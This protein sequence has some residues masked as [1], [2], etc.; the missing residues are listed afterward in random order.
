MVLIFIFL[1]VPVILLIFRNTEF[2]S[3][4]LGRSITNE[5]FLSVNLDADSNFRNLRIITFRN[6]L[7]N[8]EHS[9]LDNDIS[10]IDKIDKVNKVRKN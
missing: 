1:F 2:L 5:S 8:L 3:S 9:D 10:I 7:G 6:S 4:L